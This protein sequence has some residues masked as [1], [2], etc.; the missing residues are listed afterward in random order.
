MK[1][2]L[3]SA[4]LAACPL[5]HRCAESVGD[6]GSIRFVGQ[7]APAAELSFEVEP[8]GQGAVLVKAR[9][10]VSGVPWAG[11]HHQTYLVLGDQELL[12]M[13]APDGSFEIAPRAGA[14]ALGEL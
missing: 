10:A 4:I 8:L 5:G 9:S 2:A 11:E 1:A 7:V 3:V 6:L 12:V 13:A 14:L